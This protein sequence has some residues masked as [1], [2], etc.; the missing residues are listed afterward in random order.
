MVDPYLANLAQLPESAAKNP[1]PRMTAILLRDLQS[2]MSA[3]IV[4]ILQPEGVPPTVRD[5]SNL[6]CALTMPDSF[7]EE[8]GQTRGRL[9]LRPGDKVRC[10]WYGSEYEGN[11]ANSV[12]VFAGYLET[13]RIVWTD[14]DG[15]HSRHYDPMDCVL[16]E[17]YEVD[18]ES[19]FPW[20]RVTDEV[21]Q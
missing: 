3:R 2:G 16:V 10:R 4:Q 21:S 15:S 13:F 12:R 14:A 6:S 19:G 9:Y 11:A 18:P 7:Y 8:N 1:E 17:P 5:P 20:A